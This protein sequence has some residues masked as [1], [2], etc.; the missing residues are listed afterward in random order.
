MQ[1]V[2]VFG[3]NV[4]NLPWEERPAGSAAAV[5]RYSGNPVI[6]RHATPTSNSVLNSA[7]VPFGDQFAGV[8]RVD[9]TRRE[10]RLHAGFS[11]DGIAWEIEPEPIT[12]HVPPGV[13]PPEYGYDPRVTELDGA[14]AVTWCN[15]WHGP[16]IGLG[17]TNDF[18]SF[19]MVENALL[20]HNRN[21]VLFPR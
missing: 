15:G 9:D 7:V 11:Q 13:E 10:M 14:Y 18:R 21:G 16:T 8:F 17:T 2:R 5:W 19:T 4:P 6:G 12:W 3:P 1:S 20:P